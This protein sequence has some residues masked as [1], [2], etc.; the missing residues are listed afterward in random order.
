[1]ITCGL[2]GLMTGCAAGVGLDALILALPLLALPLLALPLLALP[3]LAL[4]CGILALPCLPL[5]CLALPCLALPC[6]EATEGMF[7]GL[8]DMMHGFCGTLA[9]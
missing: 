7:M 3:L 8:G 9:I 5:P 4:P 2:L 1:M 6:G